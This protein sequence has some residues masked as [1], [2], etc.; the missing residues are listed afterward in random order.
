V[1][2]VLTSKKHGCLKSLDEIDAVGHRVVHGKEKFKSS[3]L[4]TE[5]V[6][7]EL[8]RCVDIAPLHN[9]PNLKGIYAMQSLLPIRTP[10]GCI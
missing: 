7:Q 6:I 9:P 4:I 1:L 10:G 8:E 5:E 2:G 3:V